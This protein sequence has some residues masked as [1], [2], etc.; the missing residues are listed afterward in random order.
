MTKED[1]IAI[2]TFFPEW[3]ASL[4]PKI[5]ETFIRQAIDN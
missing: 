1:L 4:K 3:F 2:R 5:D